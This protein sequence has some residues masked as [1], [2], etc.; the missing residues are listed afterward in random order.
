MDLDQRELEKLQT[1]FQE[2]PQVLVVYLYGSRVKGYAKESSDLDVAVVIDDIHGL[3]YGKLYP[4]VSG[5]I[6][7][8]EIDLRIV[9][10][11]NNPTYLFEVIGG[12]CIYKR[13]EE[14]RINFE[15]RVMRVFYDGKYMRDIYYR[16]LKQHFGVS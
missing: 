14:D 15:T 12:R 6:K 1:I 3:D 2:L 16:Y 4:E 7:S 8:F 9:T 13:T 5:I 11:K 10:L